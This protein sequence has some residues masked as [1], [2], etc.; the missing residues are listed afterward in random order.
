M[1][2]LEAGPTHVEDH[3]SG[4]GPAR[5]PRGLRILVWDAYLGMS[6]TWK[7]KAENR[8]EFRQLIGHFYYLFLIRWDSG[9]SGLHSPPPFCPTLLLSPSSPQRSCLRPVTCMVFSK[10]FHLIVY[11]CIFM[12]PHPKL[13][14]APQ[15][16]AGSLPPHLH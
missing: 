12:H 4:A 11:L 15:N 6:S 16:G 14:Q 8:F 10:A 3:H 5:P 7:S 2:D 9:P 13:C 1:G